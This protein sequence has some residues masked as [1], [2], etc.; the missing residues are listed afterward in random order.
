MASSLLRE[1]P[2]L[3]DRSY[4]KAKCHYGTRMLFASR[5]CGAG[6]LALLRRAEKKATTMTINLTPELEKHLQ[7]EAAKEGMA[8]DRFILNTLKER[9][10]RK[11][12]GQDVPHLSKAESELMQHINQGLPEETWQR[13]H[14]LVAERK[15]ETLTPE[16]HRELIRLSDQ[17]EMDY[18]Q[19]LG[20][21]LE[22]AHLR[23]TSL[24]AQ[25]ETLGIPQYTYE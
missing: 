15:A 3:E 5:V 19:R 25:M 2:D 8:P 10:N 17:V 11:R 6:I 16:Q 12:T 21:V 13:Y 18:A 23:G 20:V 24:E 9:L 22:L 4:N 7:T 14:A 1:H